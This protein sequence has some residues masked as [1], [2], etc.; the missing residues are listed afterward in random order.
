M[1][2]ADSRCVV[3]LV[4]LRGSIGKNNKEN[5]DMENKENKDDL[6]SDIDF[7]RAQ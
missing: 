6:A 1:K 7:H 5:K 2:R 4:Y 3:L